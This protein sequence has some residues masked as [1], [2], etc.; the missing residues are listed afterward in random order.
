MDNKEL[1]R[2]L[3]KRGKRIFA[4]CL[5]QY[6]CPIHFTDGQFDRVDCYFGE[7]SVGEIKYRQ[8]EYPTYICEENKVYSLQ[9]TEM[10]YQF[11]I[12]VFDDKI[13]FWDVQTILTKY[14]VESMKLPTD[15]SKTEFI[16]KYCYLLKTDDCD[17]I[18]IKDKKE[19]KWKLTK[20]LL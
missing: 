11:Y 1:E 19:N 9:F 18:F 12:V 7:K 8:K 15:L 2:I 16:N 14:K 20:M 4:E 13:Y 10:P 3:D 6:K 17:F 5:K